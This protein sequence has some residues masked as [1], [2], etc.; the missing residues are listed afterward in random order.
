[1]LTDDGSAIY[2]QSDLYDTIAHYTISGGV[3]TFQSMLVGP[4]GVSKSMPLKYM[5]MS[6]DGGYWLSARTA[7]PTHMHPKAASI[8][9]CGGLFLIR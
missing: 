6:A 2:V 9:A 7:I 4:L 1:M 3:F 5:G 8:A